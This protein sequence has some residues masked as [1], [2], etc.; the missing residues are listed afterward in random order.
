[1]LADTINELIIGNESFEYTYK[2]TIKGLWYLH[3]INLNIL[4]T[5]PDLH[6]IDYTFGQLINGGL[7]SEEKR[8]F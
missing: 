5:Q 8:Y 1:M 4:N 6:N 2:I 7:V 3:L